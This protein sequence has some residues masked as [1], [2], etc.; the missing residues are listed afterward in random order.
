MM[1]NK[2]FF[3]LLVIFSQFSISHAADSASAIEKAIVADINLYRNQHRLAPLTMNEQMVKEARQHSADMA[4][5][6]IPFGHN[7]FMSRINRLHKQIKGS[8]AAAEN[9]AY[10]YK[11]AHDVV[12]NWLKSPGHKRN[13]DG[14]YNLT[15]V[16]I[17]YDKNGKLYFTQ[18]FLKKN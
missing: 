3:V 9:V 7:H 16:G 1:F 18:I 15:G 5:H 11:D 12:N 13:I 10:N 17:A 6:S 8:G 2:I 14:H 4:K